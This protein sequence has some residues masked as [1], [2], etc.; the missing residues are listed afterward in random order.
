M[1]G[2]VSYIPVSIIQGPAGPTG[3]TGPQGPAGPEGPSGFV[4][5]VMLWHGDWSGA[6]SYSVG[7]CVRSG[8]ATY[9][10]TQAHSNQQP[11]NATYWSV[12]S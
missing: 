1:A 7:N 6:T 5:G 12:M 11:P 4:E 9:V 3:A 2:A 8:G 10:C